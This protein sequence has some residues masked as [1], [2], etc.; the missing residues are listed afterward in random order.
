MN[1][2]RAFNRIKTGIAAFWIAIISFFSKAF[3]QDLG[4]ELQPMYGVEY[5]FGIDQP[6][7]Q[8]TLIDTII[9]LAKRPLIWITLIV[10]IINFLKIRKIKDKKQKKKKIKSSIITIAILIIL[11][12]ACIITQFL[13]KK[14]W[15]NNIIKYGN[16]SWSQSVIDIVDIIKLIFIW[17]TLLIGI[18]YLIRTRKIKDKIQKRKEII[19]TIIVVIIIILVLVR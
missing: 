5:K 19:S 12:M 4:W 17:V 16:W 3:G 13:T 8:P 7:G 1:M 9:K 14:I 11:I 2:K 6:I 15:S 18:L 10:W